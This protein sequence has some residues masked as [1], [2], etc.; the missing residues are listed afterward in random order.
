LGVQAAF[1]FDEGW[2]GLGGA[3]V[4]CVFIYAR[5]GTIQGAEKILW[6]ELMQAEQRFL[7][8]ASPTVAT[9]GE[10]SP[11]QASADRMRAR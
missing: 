7:V 5:A 2:L 4:L 10:M 8:S 9:N 1:E 3:L 11:S 6:L